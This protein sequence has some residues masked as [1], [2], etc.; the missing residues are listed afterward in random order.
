MIRPEQKLSLLS[1]SGEEISD[2]DKSV[3]MMTILREIMKEQPDCTEELAQAIHDQIADTVYRSV[4]KGEILVLFDT[5]TF[6]PGYLDLG[7]EDFP[8]D[9]KTV[10]V[11]VDVVQP[12]IPGVDPGCLVFPDPEGRPM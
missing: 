6:I 7:P 4:S 11:R 5:F 1:S 10:H 3:S 2:P 9:D 12:E 8:P